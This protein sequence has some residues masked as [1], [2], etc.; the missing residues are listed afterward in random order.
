MTRTFLD[1]D[2]E[3]QTIISGKLK[4]ASN[5][6]S[7][8]GCN[9]CPNEYPLHFKDILSYKEYKISGLCQKCQDEVF[10]S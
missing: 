10:G 7:E 5:I 6:V 2:E 1:E 3:A 4:S 8:E 9:T